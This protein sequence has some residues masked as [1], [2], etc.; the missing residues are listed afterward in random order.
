M[1]CRTSSEKETERLVI[2]TVVSPLTALLQQNGNV[3]AKQH[4][5]LAVPMLLRQLMGD[6]AVIQQT[7]RGHHCHNHEDKHS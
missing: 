2:G 1:K 3:E 5:N 6:H 4:V 7:D